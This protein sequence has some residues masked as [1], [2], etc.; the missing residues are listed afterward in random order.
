VLQSPV[1]VLDTDTAETLAARIL[2]E[3]H[4]IYSEGI[5]IV[6]EGKFHIE[7]RKVIREV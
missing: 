6:A 5:R 4:K 3:E 7:G 1:A 2:A